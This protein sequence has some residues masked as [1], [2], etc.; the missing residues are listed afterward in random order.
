[1][2]EHKGFLSDVADNARVN[3]IVVD[4]ANPDFFIAHVDMSLD[5]DTVGEVAKQAPEGLNPF[6]ASSETL[7][8]QPQTTIVKITG[9]AR[10]GGAEFVAAANMS[11][12]ALGHGK[13]A[14]WEV[15]MGIVPSGGAT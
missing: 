8:N 1:M 11:F 13:L 14:Q 3:V 5:A 12:A 6:L 7:R 9:I 2:I 15:L 4:S 10:G